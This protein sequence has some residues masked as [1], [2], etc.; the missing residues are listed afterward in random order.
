MPQYKCHGL[1]VEEIHEYVEAY[2]KT[3]KLCKD[4]GVDGV[5]VHAVHEGYL[6]DQ[7]TMPYSNHCTDEYG[8][9]FENRYRFAV[10][11]VRAI[12]AA[13]G[14]DYPVSLRYSVLS[15]TKGLNSGA[16]P[17]EDYVEVGRDTTESE[18]AIR[19]LQEAGYDSFN[20]DNGTYDAWFWAHPPVYMPLN[21]NMEDVRQKTQHGYHY[22]PATWHAIMC[23]M[24]SDFCEVAKKYGLG[25]NA[26]FY[27][28]MAHAWL[29][30]KDAVEDKAAVYYCY[31]VQH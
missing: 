17:G 11:V 23:T 6:V 29:D 21:C 14:E 24:Y 15:K 25:G 8:G 30:D 28:D 31:V 4:N 12:K 2:A 27:A 26:E 1:T 18:R 20:C 10:E 13:C 16:V 19:Y 5:E 7:F 9:S 22:D 3:A